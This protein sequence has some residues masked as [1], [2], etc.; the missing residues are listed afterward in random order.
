MKTNSVD[1]S[2]EGDRRVSFLRVLV[3]KKIELITLSIVI[4]DII[5]THAANSN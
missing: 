4:A 3:W 5:A 1:S 2:H